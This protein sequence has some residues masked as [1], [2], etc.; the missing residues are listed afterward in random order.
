MSA[1]E[2]RLSV[3]RRIF[4][5]P[6]PLTA[7]ET[8]T[9][10]RIADALIPAHQENPAA[11][12]APDYERWLRRAIGARAEQFDL[13]VQTIAML[14]DT[15]ED[16]ML[17][18]LRSLDRTGPK[19]FHLLSSVVAGAYVMV[20]EVRGLIGYPG[21]VRNIPT[22]EEAVDQISDGILDPVLERDPIFVPTPTT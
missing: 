2:Q 5:P 4:A 19:A 3:P 21:Q 20:P 15:S 22:L 14:S 12:Q 13:L 18:A 16:Q 8:A 1:D 17:E 9:L 10:M 7:L 11:S 6:R